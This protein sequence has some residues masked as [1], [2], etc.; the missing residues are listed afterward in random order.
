MATLNY[1]G[2]DFIK[3]HHEM[4]L[5]TYLRFLCM[6][7]LGYN[8]LFYKEFKTG[9]IVI[10]SIGVVLNIIGIGIQQ[11]FLREQTTGPILAY[12]IQT[13]LVPSI[14]FIFQLSKLSRRE[15]YLVISSFI[16]FVVEQILF[17]KRLPLGRV[18]FVVLL[19]S[20]ATSYLQ[21][22]GNN[23]SKV[24]VYFIRY[25]SISI[26]ITIAFSVVGLN[27]FQYVTATVD[28]FFSEGN[29]T[30]TV[31]SDERWKIGEIIMED[32]DRT[33]QLIFGK[34]FGGVVYDN[35]FL[36]ETDSG[37]T[38][39]SASEMGLPT[40]FLK[41]GIILLIIMSLIVLRALMTYNYIKIDNF[42]FACWSFVLVWAV[43]LYGEGFIGAIRSLTEIILGYAIGF[44]LRVAKMKS[45][46]PAL[47]AKA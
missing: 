11:T 10:M 15:N 26:V 7:L 27:L 42:S 6:M 2:I 17:Q 23:A 44:L 33:D 28:R 32:L 35:S 20:Y 9:L 30:E 38:Y 24:L 47:L 19:L 5:Y 46:W 34:G 21:A 25:G 29:V 8:F 16:L 14:F 39:R 3:E 18:F 43:F 40:I 37:L 36:M 12:N 4:E 45:K 1:G 22:Y 13:L 41:G 31:E